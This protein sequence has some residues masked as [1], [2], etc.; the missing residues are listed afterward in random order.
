VDPVDL[1]AA[2]EK[3]LATFPFAEG[4]GI[5][6]WPNAD[7]ELFTTAWTLLALSAARTAKSPLAERW[8]DQARQGLFAGLA[9]PSEPGK[10]NAFHLA[11][12]AV[13]ESGNTMPGEWRD[14]LV[15]E[16]KSIFSTAIS[17]LAL[18]KIDPNHP[19]I[20]A[21][22]TALSLGLDEEVTTARVRSTPG[23]SDLPGASVASDQAAVLWAFAQAWPEHPVVAKLVSGLLALRTGP[24]WDTTFG[25]AMALYALS[26]VGALREGPVKASASVQIGDVV[27]VTKSPMPADGRPLVRAWPLAETP[28]GGMSEEKND[29]LIVL[30]AGADS[31]ITY[32]LNLSHV[33]V[34][35]ALAA[36]AGIALATPFRTRFGVLGERESVAVGEIVAI[37]VSLRSES[38]REHVAVEIPLP[39]GFEPFE[40][41]LGKQAH[42][43]PPNLAP[44]RQLPVAFEEYHS[45]RIRLFLRRL[46]PGLPRR[47]TVYAYAKVPGTFTVPGAHAQAMYTPTVRGRATTRQ[48]EIALPAP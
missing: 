24:D 10:G 35:V 7:P 30:G 21:K 26:A 39:A 23:E 22:L 38:A 48:I 44:L 27:L 6:F 42:A 37:D 40:A 32:S 11:L 9:K 14:R 4:R 16:N 20:R 2:T 29:A 8:L 46:D 41:D 18:T 34:D 17:A 13:A 1:F 33:P 25:N 31:A 19:A 3:R 12:L 5:G 47:H 43:L 15:G 28:I 45:D 36:N